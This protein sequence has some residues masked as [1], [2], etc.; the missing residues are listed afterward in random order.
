MKTKLIAGNAFWWV[1]ASALL[2]GAMTWLAVLG[3]AL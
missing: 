2:I 3:G 1:A